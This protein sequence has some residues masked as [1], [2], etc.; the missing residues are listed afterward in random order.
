MA[1]QMQI[2]TLNRKYPQMSA[3]QIAQRLGCLPEYVRAT[4]R[5]RGLTLAKSKEGR[6]PKPESLIM[7]GHAAREAGLT[8]QAIIAIGRA[9]GGAA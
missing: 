9:K 3:P 8:V 6:T 4:A 5:R 2:I 1:D 7:L